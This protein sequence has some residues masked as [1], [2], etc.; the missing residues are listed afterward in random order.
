MSGV[1]ENL[2]YFTTFIFRFEIEKKLRKARKKGEKSEQMAGDD[3][4]LSPGDGGGS[5]SEGTSRAISKKRTSR[6]SQKAVDVGSNM[7]RTTAERARDTKSRAM[8]D[9]ITK[10]EEKKRAGKFFNKIFV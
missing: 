4:R 10:R 9:L 1:L 7:R 6:S 3:Y 8:Q 5:P 2:I